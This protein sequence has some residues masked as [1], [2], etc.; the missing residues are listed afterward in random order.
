MRIPRRAGISNQ[1]FRDEVGIESQ[2][3]RVRRVLGVGQT[4]PPS[5]D[6]VKEARAVSHLPE[7]RVGQVA[8]GGLEHQ[9][10]D[11][12]S[13]GKHGRSNHRL[14]IDAA[15]D[16]LRSGFGPTGRRA[17]PERPHEWEERAP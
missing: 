10:P 1:G 12:P 17:P 11:S 3:D 8:E 7:A 4:H 15:L 13:A 5:P 6:E 14:D 2:S 16:S 9:P